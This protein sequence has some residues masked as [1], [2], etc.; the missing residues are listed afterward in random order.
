M[1]AAPDAWYA[2]LLTALPQPERLA[3]HW[4]LPPPPTT[5]QSASTVHA[6]IA[7]PET[8][9]VHLAIMSVQAVPHLIGAS[10]ARQKCSLPK[11][12]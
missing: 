10:G 8:R 1:S 6:V 9:V 7:G 3:T 5:T 4:Q 12:R 2:T 11:E